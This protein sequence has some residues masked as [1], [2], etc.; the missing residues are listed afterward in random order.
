[1]IEAHGLGL[2]SMASSSHIASF[3]YDAIEVHSSWQSLD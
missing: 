2:L 3:R 1:L